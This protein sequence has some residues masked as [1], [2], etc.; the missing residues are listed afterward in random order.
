LVTSRETLP[1]SRKLAWNAIAR[2]FDRAPKRDVQHQETAL[3][4]K[5]LDENSAQNLQK[6]QLTAINST[7]NLLKFS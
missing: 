2:A 5:L 7:V 3:I 6:Y 1:L 4:K